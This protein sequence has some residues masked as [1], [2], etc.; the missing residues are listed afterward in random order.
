MLRFALRTPPV[1]ATSERR[2]V[3]NSVVIAQFAFAT[4]LPAVACV[5]LALAR[6]NPRVAALDNRAWQVIVGVVFGLIAIYGTEAGIP[7]DGAMMNVR[8]DKTLYSNATTGNG[9]GLTIDK[10]KAVADYKDIA[11]N[12]H[13]RGKHNPVV[14]QLNNILNKK[15]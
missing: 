8:D 4:L 3:L 10:P 12:N 13:N 5:L 9:K 14:S 7:V 2:H 1:F 15:P 6:K 11:Q